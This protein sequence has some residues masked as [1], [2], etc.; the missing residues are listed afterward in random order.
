VLPVS[1]SIGATGLGFVAERGSTLRGLAPFIAMGT[2]FIV[3]DVL[4]LLLV[5]PFSAA[6]LYAFGESGDPINIVYFAAMMIVTS[7]VILFL[8]RFRRGI[9]VK[10]VLR[11]VILFSLFSTFY[12]LSWFRL[13]DP[14]AIGVSAIFSLCI[15]WVVIKWPRWYVIDAAAILLGTVTTTILGISLA[16]P[17]VAILLLLLAVYDA[18]S[19]YK[20]KHM[21]VLA[22]AILNSG[23][24]LVL[25]VPR[26]GYRNGE[27]VKIVKEGSQGER[28]AF[29]IGLGD[30]VLPG[31]L[32]VSIYSTLG[33]EGVPVLFAV[34]LGTLVG[35]V[36]L[37]A[38][39]SRGKPQAGLP[40]LCC[41][42]VL[43]YV[44]SSYIQYRGLVGFV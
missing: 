9:F 33:F 37:S 38:F 19:V 14:L 29:Y 6:G 1:S 34:W 24:P 13:G 22:E 25:I 15:V 3:V 12:S 16:A 2:L 17:L 42:A 11:V 20:T 41:G 8:R 23:L 18:V 30:L 32:S 26:R 39:V 21:L 28:R 27:K 44:V 35:F 43:G 40:F 4:S 31:T 7:G 10:W 5:G 36:V